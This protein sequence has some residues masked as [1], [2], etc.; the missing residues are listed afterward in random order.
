MKVFV[1]GSGSRGNAVALQAESNTL[2]IDAGFGVR[3]LR[4]R[5]K[6]AGIELESVAGILLTHEHG[7][8]SRGAAALARALRC[9]VYGSHGTLRALRRR[10]R[11]LDA[12][13]LPV[14]ELAQVCGFTVTTC[15]TSHDALEPI[16]VTVE[17]GLSRLKLGLAYDVGRPT[18][19]LIE[20]L[21]DCHCLLV[22]AN[23]DEGMLRQ[24]PY[25]IHVR[26]RIAGPGGHL[27]NRAA[28]N[29]LRQLV[30][31]ELGTVVLLHLSDRCNR[32]Q[33]AAREIRAVLQASGF[34]GRLHIAP[35]DEPLQPIDL[36]QQ[37]QQLSLG[38]SG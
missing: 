37:D 7:D 6:A 4:R 26:Q 32:P 27:S 8:H 15:H 5:A 38:L 24:G 17:S 23:H 1:L 12:V 9:P 31:P 3:S 34:G 2:L 33:L 30:H 14:G 13:L 22:E 28:A 35:Q 18:H 11:E 21:R 29:L 25:P 36:L 20:L 10:Q 16:A 19:R